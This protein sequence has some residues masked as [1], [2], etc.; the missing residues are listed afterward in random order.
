MVA[1]RAAVLS[2]DLAGGLV[3]GQYVECALTE[4]WHSWLEAG[5][6]QFLGVRVANPPVS[7]NLQLRR[8]FAC[9][10]CFF[11]VYCILM[12]RVLQGCDCCVG[13]TAA[14]GSEV[15]FLNLSSKDEQ[16]ED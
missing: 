7:C 6:L 8:F 13:S 3:A 11:T 12:R 15:F 14:M 2:R 16:L 9:I 4:F 1:E 10:I 5:G